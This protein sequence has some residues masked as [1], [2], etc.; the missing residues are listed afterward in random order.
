[1][2][3]FF[4]RETDYADSHSSADLLLGGSDVLMDE[5]Y[6]WQDGSPVTYANFIHGFPD[7]NDY[8]SV[9]LNLGRN[10][11]VSKDSSAV[12]ASVCKQGDLRIQQSRA[13]FVSFF[14][15]ILLT[16]REV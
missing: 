4:S 3:G 11:W 1:M 13:F 2:C 16:H 15:F 14:V 5:T 9:Y 12:R 10:E 8:L 6:L 7:G